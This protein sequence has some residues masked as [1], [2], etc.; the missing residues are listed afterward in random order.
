MAVGPSDVAFRDSQHVGTHTCILMTGLIPFTLSHCG[1][2]SPCVRF[3]A[4]IT[5]YD[6]T[7]G[8]RCLATASGAGAFPRLTEPSFARRTSNGEIVGGRALR[9]SSLEKVLSSRF[10]RNELMR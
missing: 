10:A 1:P 2:S 4:G 5:D 6:A 8:T 3:A 9:A 7:L